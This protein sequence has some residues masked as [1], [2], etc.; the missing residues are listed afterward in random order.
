MDK[1][2]GVS[3]PRNSAL[4]TISSTS[5]SMPAAAYRVFS[6]HG[7]K[8][9]GASLL[10]TEVSTPDRIKVTLNVDN[11][12]GNAEKVTDKVADNINDTQIKIFELIRNDPR[13]TKRS[14]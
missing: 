1:S 11:G 5:A 13:I 3:D 14:A 8:K 10:S 9:S 12:G 7:I 2:G 4:I 6:L